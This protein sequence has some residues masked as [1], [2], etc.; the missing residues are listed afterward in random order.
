MVR[1]DRDPSRKFPFIRAVWRWW[2]ERLTGQWFLWPND[3][4]AVEAGLKIGRPNIL[5]ASNPT[6][7]F[8]LNSK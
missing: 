6:Q 7:I 2:T 3:R 4:S 8:P 1:K 5:V